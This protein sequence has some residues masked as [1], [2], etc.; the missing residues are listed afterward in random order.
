VAVAA[1]ALTD[2]QLDTLTAV[3]DTFVPA[4]ERED[5]PHGFWG[6]AASDVGVPGAMTVAFGELPADQAAGVRS[7]LDLIADV[8]FLEGSPERR[9]EILNGFGDF[10]PSRQ[11]F[12][13]FR[14]FA[15]SLFYA[16]PDETGSNPSWP[17]L[18]YPGPPD[19]PVPDDPRLPVTEPDAPLELDADVCVIGSGAGGSVVAAELAARGRRV[20]VLERG[21][22]FD[23][24]DFEQLELWAYRQLYLGGGPF[25]T[26][27]GQVALLAGGALGGGTTVNYTNCLRTPDRVREEWERDHGLEGVAG[28]DFDRHLDAVLARIGATDRC[29][30]LNGPH[31]RLEEGCAA[32]GYSFR[33]AVR[34]ADPARY[35]PAT[36]GFMGFG[37]RS[38]SKLGTIRTYLRD[39]VE[40]GAELVVGCGAERV[41]VDGPGTLTVRAAS[42]PP[43]GGEPVEVTVRARQVAV[44]GGSIESPALLLR[45]GLGGEAAG[46]NLRLH[47]SGVLFGTYDEDQDSWWGPPQAGLCDEFADTGEGHGFLV[48]CPHV[49]VGTAAASLPWLSGRQHKEQM[50]EL[51]RTAAL[52]FLVR[53]RGGG[54][55]V[56]GDGGEARARYVLEDEVDVASFREGLVRVAR[57][58]EA[59]GAREVVAQDRAATTW[60]RGE[61]LEAF[62]DALAGVSLA[63][64]QYAMFSGHQMCT[65][66]M[67]RDPGTSV[68]DPR[69]ALHDAPDVWVADASAFPTATGANPMVSV[70]ALARRTAEAMAA[71]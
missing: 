65:C 13:A 63:P 39:A 44:A 40:H 53:D 56:L 69:G 19:V 26:E 21:G 22:Y 64:Y 36:A 62:L 14:S 29:S 27:E 33:R 50:H 20:V 34:N 68:A 10:R 38:G 60:R 55:V 31:R 51:P 7:F 45:S 23:S 12:H 42:A 6:R 3:C 16:I 24:A 32:L 59:S 28:A 70:M 8:G 57:I 18:R 35:D 67:G 41:T 2:R 49:S 43:G 5:D 71:A 9:E 48:E 66:R 11:G 46:R 4:I 17:A 58:L 52:S 1:G 37:D 25:P 15:T 54:R 47:P 61:D 30:D